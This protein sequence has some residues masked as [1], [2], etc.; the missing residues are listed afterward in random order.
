MGILF[1]LGW[2]SILGIVVYSTRM[3]FLVDHFDDEANVDNMELDSNGRSKPKPKAQ[4]SVNK[5]FGKD[6]SDA[7]APVTSA[8]PAIP[9]K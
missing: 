7:N 3:P 5:G 8:D 4:P 2:I 9:T 1:S 6:A